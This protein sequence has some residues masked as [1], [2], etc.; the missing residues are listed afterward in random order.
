MGKKPK[1]GG[2][3]RKRREQ[4]LEDR[5]QSERFI[6]TAQEL[7]ADESGAC[8]ENAARKIIHAVRPRKT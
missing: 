5:E 1:A 8:F 2:A 3:P 6:A 4:K 7:G